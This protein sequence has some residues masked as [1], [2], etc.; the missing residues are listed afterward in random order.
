MTFQKLDSKW[1]LRGIW[2]ESESLTHVPLWALVCPWKNV[3]GTPQAGRA[4]KRCSP[5]EFTSFVVDSSRNYANPI[6]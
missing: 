6:L 5:S 3:L 2:L 1:S 4:F